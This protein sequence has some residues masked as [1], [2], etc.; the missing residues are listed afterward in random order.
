M[1]GRGGGG[2]GD[3]MAV[4]YYMS[5]D[6]TDMSYYYSVTLNIVERTGRYEDYLIHKTMKIFRLVNYF[7]TVRQG[8]LQAE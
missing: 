2:V 1:V 6:E 3:E 4:L 5:S 8:T 7:C